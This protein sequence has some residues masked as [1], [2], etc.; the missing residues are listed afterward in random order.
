MW[1]ARH[2]RRG[3]IGA[4]INR[5]RNFIKYVDIGFDLPAMLQ[6]IGRRRIACIL[7][8]RPRTGGAHERLA[9]VEAADE[10]RHRGR[11]RPVAKYESGVPQN[12]APFR[13]PER[14]V[15]EAITK[16]RIV[17]FKEPNQID[18][19]GIVARLKLS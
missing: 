3:E 5:L 14:R 4:M 11:R 16:R 6:C 8:E 15:A 13:P 2:K 18:W 19:V 9:I 7:P 10:R 17:Q 1:I 12:A